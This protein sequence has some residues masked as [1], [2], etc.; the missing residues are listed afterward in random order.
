MPDKTITTNDNEPCCI[1]EWAGL[2]STHN[3][4]NQHPDEAYKFLKRF[5]VWLRDAVWNDIQQ[6]ARSFEP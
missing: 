6:V 2:L 1:A 5:E 4:A 3:F